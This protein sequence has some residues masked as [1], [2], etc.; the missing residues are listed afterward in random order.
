MPL[1]S[2]SKKKVKDKKDL[3]D[4]NKWMGEQDGS[5]SRGADA[6]RGSVREPSGGAGVADVS[7]RLDE[8]LESLFSRV[9]AR[10]ER[11]SS[12]R[13]GDSLGESLQ[14]AAQSPSG[15]ANLR[16]RLA[17]V[18]QFGH[19]CN[20]LGKSEQAGGSE[21]DSSARRGSDVL[22]CSPYAKT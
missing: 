10:A 13:I 6:E 8:L 21:S 22:K 5:A 1:F 7:R 12:Q 18:R 15:V 14:G 16:A 11:G 19:S 2:N 17:A 9:N 3:D 4:A 20:A